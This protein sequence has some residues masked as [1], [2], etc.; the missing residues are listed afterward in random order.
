MV[1][2]AAAPS[3]GEIELEVGVAG[4]DRRHRVEL[5][6][7]HGGTAEVGVQQDAGGVDHRDDP[8]A[9]PCLEEPAR[10]RCELL[11]RGGGCPAADG[12]P[13]LVDHPAGGCRLQGMGLS[14]GAGAPRGT[15]GIDQA[16]HLGQLP[17]RFVH[18]R[19]PRFYASLSCWSCAGKLS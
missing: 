7:A 16:V 4:G 15:E 12:T 1:V 9:A 2:A 10:G 13:R 18:K 17:E 6:A 19:F 11:H 3:L 14:P 8:A 5:A